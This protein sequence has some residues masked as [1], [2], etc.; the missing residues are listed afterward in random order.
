MIRLEFANELCGL[1][2]VW[3]GAAGANINSAIEPLTSLLKVAQA[4]EG[5]AGAA[6]EPAGRKNLVHGWFG[7]GPVDQFEVGVDQGD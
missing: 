3:F 4:D 1:A 7:A 2:G 5:A 6:L